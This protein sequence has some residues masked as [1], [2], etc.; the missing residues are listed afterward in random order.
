MR[1]PCKAAVRNDQE[2]GAFTVC[3]FA[4]LIRSHSTKATSPVRAGKVKVPT[5]FWYCGSSKPV[6]LLTR[7]PKPLTISQTPRKRGR[8]RDLYT[9][10]PR[11]ISHRPQ[12]IMV[13]YASLLARSDL[14]AFD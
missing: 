6:K 13:R 11:G 8:K 1:L 9:S 4:P 2:A 14:V 12:K 10:I 3:S 7:Y 5:A